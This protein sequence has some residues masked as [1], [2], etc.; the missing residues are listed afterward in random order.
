[1]LWNI[2][3]VCALASLS[4]VAS[5]ACAQEDH[6]AATHDAPDVAA[7]T[8]EEQA[9]FR[10][11]LPEWNPDPESLPPELR[12]L[13]VVRPVLPEDVAAEVAE[14]EARIAELEPLGLSAET[15]A[16]QNAALDEAIELAERVLALRVEHQGN[17]DGVVRWRDAAG[18]P[19]EWHEVIAARRTLADLQVI[20]GLDD[21]ARAELASLGGT[22]AEVVRLYGAGDFTGAQ[23]ITERQ[24]DIH[25]R[26]LGDEHPS[27]LESIGNMGVL[28]QA[29]GKLSEAEPYN[30]EAL[31]GR[32]RVL[33]GEHPNTLTSINNMG[34]LLQAQGKLAEAEPYYREA[35]EA[36]RLVSGD[37]HP[38][39][40]ASINNMGFVLQAQGKLAE[41]EPYY[42]EALEG[43][44]R[45]LGGEHP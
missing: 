27:A 40:L 45:V 35:L 7:E 32:R 10:L 2:R 12:P 43:R 39:T 20:R 1:M 6:P 22:N 30:R 3:L 38:D 18:E 31:E 19:V 11:N 24:L 15:R 29:Q 21:A 33:G 14:L 16:E 26:V 28:L 25:R 8:T 9:P 37:D 13:D 17:T 4:T 5:V 34:L 44:R 36:R 42:R 41:A 23:A